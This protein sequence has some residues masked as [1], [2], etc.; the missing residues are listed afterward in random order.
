[1]FAAH[2]FTALLVLVAPLVARADV[3]PSEPGPGDSFNAGATCH[4]NWIGD[5]NS[6]TEWKNMAI[7]LMTGSNLGMV[8]LT[9][10]ATNQDG[11]K[12]GTFTFP[13]PQVNPYSAI[14]FFQYS[15][16]LATDRT[17]TTRFTIASPS[18][19]SVPPP[20]ATQPDSNDAIPWGT[21]AL[22]D[23]STAVAAPSFGGGAASPSGAVSS[24]PAS[25]PSAPP[26]V[27]TK[28][29]A[30]TLSKVVSST[31]SSAP[32]TT[33]TPSNKTTTS[34]A[35]VVS[36]DGRLWMSAAGLVAASFMW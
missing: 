30:S 26:A 31:G 19:Q 3:T 2:A 9:T 1:M 15:S 5:T 18:G 32:S 22:V 25:V 7:E 34:A 14:Y 24:P 28:A 4:T 29:P 8:H 16:P 20:N 23:P 6:T 12:D 27:P 21:G 10:V 36:F 35:S 13:C 33:G 11:T 17:W